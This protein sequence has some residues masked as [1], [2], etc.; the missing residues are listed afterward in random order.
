MM[1]RKSGFELVQELKSH[2]ATRGIPIILLT[3]RGGSAA[4]SLQ[5]GADDYLAKPFDPSE[6]DARVLALLRITQLE[7]EL[8]TTNEQLASELEA[9]RKVQESFM[10]RGELQ[11]SG[12]DIAG[13]L[14]PA[15]QLAGDYFDFFPSHNGRLVGIAVGDVMGHGASSALVTAV[16]KTSLTSHAGTLQPS[17]I[18]TGLGHSVWDALSG[19]K[20]MTCFYG[21]LD[22][23]G[24]R[25]RFANAGHTMPFIYSHRERRVTAYPLPGEPIGITRNVNYVERELI[26]E[27]GDVC[28][29]Y[30]D[31]L[32]EATRP[33][34]HRAYGMRRLANQI[35]E[36]V[37]LPARDMAEALI[38]DVARFSGKVF[39]DDMTAV[40]IKTTPQISGHR[41]AFAMPR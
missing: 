31:G 16:A 3:A 24:R 38:G 23:H 21:L 19:L 10:P 18:L 1:P 41:A 4:E 37:D 7:R 29:L 33:D 34:S 32:V 14:V 36:S 12:F 26:L 6:L 11:I 39:E 9:A 25:L 13:M 27:P 17:K 20:H 28:V 22:A 5:G 40:I 8:R 15:T 30:S 35:K 2:P